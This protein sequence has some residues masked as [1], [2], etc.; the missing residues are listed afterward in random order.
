MFE[1]IRIPA[2]KDN[3]I[4][5]LRK[6]LAA[7]VVDPGDAQPVLEVLHR[8]GLSLEAILITHHHQDHQGGVA[9]LLAQF[10]AEVFG[11]ATESITAL[12]RPLHGS[13]SF[14]L[15]AL[16]QDFQV[17]ATPGHTRGHVAY[18]G[19]GCLFCGDTLFAG[20]C[21]R[22][23]EGTAA[24][25]W[26][27]LSRLAALPDETSIYCAHEYTEANLRFAL[28]VEPGNRRLRDRVDQVAVDRAKGLPTIPSTLAMEKATNPFLRCAVP[29][30]IA[31]AR[32]HDA[33]SDE[34]VDVFAA[35]RSWKNHF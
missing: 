16:D 35:L 30:V 26:G 15:P 27:S 20:G 4:W 2:F 8:E 19:A 1:I 29:E 5:L 14:H 13:E 9:A 6:G 31:A 7:A 21:G 23:F 3:Y 24:Q 34:P 25:M 22:L 11:P 18:L 28:S 12:T 32:R 10:P 33:A 17:L